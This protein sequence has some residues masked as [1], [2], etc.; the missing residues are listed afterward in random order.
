MI[1]KIIFSPLWSVAALFALA[2]V[3]LINPSFIESVRLRYFDTLITN[4][5]T[6]ENNIYTVN[7]DEESIKQHGQWPWPR[8][9]YAKLIKDLY[10]RGAG[11]VVFNVLMPSC[12][13]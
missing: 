5:T 13:P 7:I 4:Q 6:V 1:R 2:Y 9:E 10:D 11:L 3:Q 12:N 8:D